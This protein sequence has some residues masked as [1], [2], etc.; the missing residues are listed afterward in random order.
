MCIRVKINDA[1]TG[2]IVISDV[3]TAFHISLI[4]V[5]TRPEMKPIAAVYLSIYIKIKN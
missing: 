5:D 1:I 4:C 3:C 2:T